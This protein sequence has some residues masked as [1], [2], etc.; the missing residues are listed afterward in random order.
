VFLYRLGMAALGRLLQQR[1]QRVLEA[2]TSK[3]E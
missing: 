2:V 1:E 3:S